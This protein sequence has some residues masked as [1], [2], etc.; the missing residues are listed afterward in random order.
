ME[1]RQFGKTGMRA[2]MLGPC[3]LGIGPGRGEP[4]AVA[5]LVGESWGPLGP[6]G[7]GRTP[8]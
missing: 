4:E 1:R 6:P 5:R 2:G 7:G 3:G 8:P